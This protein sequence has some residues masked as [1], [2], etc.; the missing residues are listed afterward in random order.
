[1]RRRSLLAVLV[2]AVLALTGAAP[3][4]AQDNTAIA[5]NTKDNSSTIDVA[6]DF[7]RVM[8]G[9]VDQSNAAVAYASCN[10][11]QT[12]A[13]AVQVVL[14]VGDVDVVTPTN[15]A[16]AINQNCTTCMTVA[17]AYQWVFGDGTWLRF[18]HDAAMRLHA[19]AQAF[20]DLEKSGGTA[21]EVTT[22]VNQLMTDL[23]TVLAT[24]LEP[25]PGQHGAPEQTGAQQTP[26]PTATPT[27]TPTP[28]ASA[29]PE[30]TATP[31]A[32]TTPEPTATA[33]P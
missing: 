26:E 13:V 10:E 3:A 15:F 24:G 22:K 18:T 17:L 28:E 16:M 31:E 27:E 29:T 5:V 23:T 30:P 19:I 11:C 20:H 6:F 33:T 1:M 2:A 4:A 9:I 25:A 8:N 14:A 32:T 12:I 21:D 7:R